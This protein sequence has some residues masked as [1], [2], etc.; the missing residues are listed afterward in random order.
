[1][2]KTILSALLFLCAPGWLYAQ[3]QQE[4]EQ[5][6]IKDEMCA[7]TQ[8]QR[9]L[10]ITLKD[11]GGA[12]YDRTFEVFPAVV[13]PFGFMVAAG[14]TVYIEADVVDG[15]LTN[16]VAVETVTHPD[17]TITAEFVQNDDNGM[18]L[19]VNNPFRK[20]LRFDM[21]I[22][23]LGR[24]DLYKTSSCPVPS[25]LRSIEHW[26]YPIFQVALGNGRFL[27]ESDTVACD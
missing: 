25:G 16:L 8:C 13:Q 9:N 11:E 1:M 12:T 3:D 2:N 22:M 21:G 23:P 18:F 4:D 17:K 7:K 5:Q 24:D 27:E 15:K 26:P 10:R 6:R 20:M 19:T 14:Q